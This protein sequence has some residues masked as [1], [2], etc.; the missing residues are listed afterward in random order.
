MRKR[1]MLIGCTLLVSMIYA[2][3]FILLFSQDKSQ[4]VLLVS[5]KN[6]TSDSLYWLQ[7][8]VFKEESSYQN[9]K[10]ELIEKGADV[11]CVDVNGLTYVLVSPMSDEITLDQLMNEL[12][13]SEIDVIKKQA[14][15]N[16]SQKQLFS[17]RQLDELMKELVNQ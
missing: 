1:T 16:E 17:E 10:S 8:G 12:T 3:G 9:L 5:D 2:G 11:V 7:A 14:K 4:S 13:A 6:E 15:L